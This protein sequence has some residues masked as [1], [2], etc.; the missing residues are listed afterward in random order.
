MKADIWIECSPAWI[1]LGTVG[2]GHGQQEPVRIRSDGNELVAV[3]GLTLEE[4]R[5][6]LRVEQGELDHKMLG[7]QQMLGPLRESLN[8]FVSRSGP[9]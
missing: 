7:L 4:G 9:H 5:R 8:D 6:R 2:V 1:V 3:A